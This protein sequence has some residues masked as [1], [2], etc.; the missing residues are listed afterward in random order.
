MATYEVLAKKEN[1]F[2]ASRYGDRDGF[3]EREFPYQLYFQE[4][5]TLEEHESF[6][7]KGG[8]GTLLIKAGKGDREKMRAV[9]REAAARYGILEYTLLDREGEKLYTRPEL[10]ELAN[11]GYPQTAVFRWASPWVDDKEGRRIRLDNDHSS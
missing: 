7:G 6:Y 2:D 9:Y 3:Y 11:K 5:N 8:F 1:T 10:L 4:I